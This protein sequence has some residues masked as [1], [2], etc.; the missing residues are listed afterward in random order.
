MFDID[1]AEFAEMLGRERHT[2]KR[3]LTD[4]RFFSGIGGAYADEIMHR[5]KLSPLVL[6]DR[7]DDDDIVRLHAASREVLDEW[8]LDGFVNNGSFAFAHWDGDF[9]LFS[10]P[11]L[12]YLHYFLTIARHSGL[13]CTFIL[14]F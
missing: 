13:P 7:L 1:A 8:T 6:T 3:S 10:L 2:L 11:F 4:P 9:Y 12:N 5:A 14:L